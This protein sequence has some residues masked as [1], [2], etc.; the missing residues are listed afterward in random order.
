MS[1]I[2]FVHLSRVS[3]LLVLLQ[4]LNITVLVKFRHLPVLVSAILKMR[5]ETVTYVTVLSG[6][7]VILLAKIDFLR[8]NYTYI[9]VN[10]NFCEGCYPLNLVIDKMH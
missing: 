1:C 7:T 5:I 6:G 3:H 8:N 2:V 4:V 9:N 10:G